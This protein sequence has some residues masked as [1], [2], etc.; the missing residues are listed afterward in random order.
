MIGSV[1]GIP[2]G[3]LLAFLD[4]RAFIGQQLGAVRNAMARF[5]A[6]IVIDQH[7]FAVTRHDDQAAFAVGDDVLVLD[8]QLG[9]ERGFD[10][11][12]FRA[13]LRRAAD[14]EGTHRKLRARFADRLRGDN[15]DRFADIDRRAAREIAPIALGANAHFGFAGQGR[16]DEQPYRYR[17]YRSASICASSISSPAATMTCAVFGSM[18]ST[19]AVRPRIRSD[20]RRDNFAAFDHRLDDEAAFR[21]RNRVR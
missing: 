14:V 21:C 12:L 1:Y 19:R 3:E 16:A 20:K 7:E 5:F 10:R 2:F 18:M 8:L 15:A 9:I 17:L 13:T 4:R 11:A 6:A